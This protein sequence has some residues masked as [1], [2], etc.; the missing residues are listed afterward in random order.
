MTVLHF[1]SALQVQPLDFPGILNDN[2]VEITPLACFGVHRPSCSSSLLS[3]LTQGVSKE[4][5]SSWLPLITC[6]KQGW[7]VHLWWRRYLSLTGKAVLPFR[8]HLSHTWKWSLS[9]LPVSVSRVW[10]DKWLFFFPPW[11]SEFQTS[12]PKKRCVWWCVRHA[13]AC[14]DT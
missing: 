11:N 9:W 14:S 8:N 13:R 4:T 3:Y 6:R 10:I 1:V 5:D 12:V 7:K 2:E